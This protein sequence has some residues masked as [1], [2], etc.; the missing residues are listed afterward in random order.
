MNIH[1]VQQ[2]SDWDGILVVMLHQLLMMICRRTTSS[3]WV[4]IR[5]NHQHHHQQQQQLNSI[6]GSFSFFV[7]IFQRIGI[8]Y[9][10]SSFD[11]VL[12]ALPW[13]GKAST[14]ADSAATKSSSYDDST[15]FTPNNK[16]QNEE[17]WWVPKLTLDP[18]GIVSSENQYFYSTKR[19]YSLQFKLR[20]RTKAPSLLF[21][22]GFAPATIDDD[23][24]QQL[25]PTVIRLDCITLHNNNNDTMI[26]DGLPLPN[27]NNKDDDQER[28]FHFKHQYCHQHNYGGHQLRIQQDLI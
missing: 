4:K 27:N 15:E 10:V 3:P 9:S 19:Q 16:I 17:D 12:S 13:V 7:P 26:E 25:I 24:Q 8:K 1:R 2:V 6:K 14:T 20:I 23:I 22:P 21:L 5:F 28:L 18:F 11:K